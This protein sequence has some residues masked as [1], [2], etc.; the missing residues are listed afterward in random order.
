MALTYGRHPC[1]SGDP[2][3][4]AVRR[5]GLASAV[6][7]KVIFDRLTA[8]YLE[9]GLIYMATTCHSTQD[10]RLCEDEKNERWGSLKDTVPFN[11]LVT[12]FPRRNRPA[13]SVR[14][15]SK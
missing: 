14:H 5:I 10:F 2:T 6:R 11:L 9:I 8:K 15:S 3:Y 1:A 12:A 7:C 4:R 13:A